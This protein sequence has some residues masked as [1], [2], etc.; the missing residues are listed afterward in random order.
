[1]VVA[2]CHSEAVGRA[3]VAAKKNHVVCIRA[4]DELDDTTATTFASNFY[5][6]LLC[7]TNAT[8][9]GAFQFADASLR[10]PDER[11]SNRFLLLP[12][13]GAHDAEI[14]SGLADSDTEGGVDGTLLSAAGADNFVGRGSEMAELLA[15]IAS[16][17]RVISVCGLSG[18]GKTALVTAT[19]AYMLA[20]PR[21]KFPRSVV[22]KLRDC[23]SVEDASF[24]VRTAVI[25]GCDEGPLFPATRDLKA[26]LHGLTG[27]LL[28]VLE[29]ADVLL[30]DPAREAGFNSLLGII[31][32]NT[33]GSK[34]VLTLVTSRRVA[35]RDFPEKVVTLSAMVP[36]EA[37]RLFVQ[38]APQPLLAKDAQAALRVAVGGSALGA[39][40]HQE[41]RSADV[42]KQDMFLEKLRAATG[43]VLE[44]QVFASTIVHL[45]LLD[46]LAGYP[47]AIV[48][49]AV[50]TSRFSL[51]DVTMRV[52]REGAPGIDGVVVAAVAQQLEWLAGAK[53]WAYWLLVL[54]GM[55]PGG[56]SVEDLAMLWG[57]H[58]VNYCPNCGAQGSGDPPPAVDI[59]ACAA[60]MCCGAVAGMCPA[61]DWSLA[62]CVRVALTDLCTASLAQQSTRRVQVDNGAVVSVLPV[63]GA[64]AIERASQS[65][66]AWLR[67]VCISS[68]AAACRQMYDRL[69]D[70][71]AAFEVIQKTLAREEPNVWQCLKWQSDES[72]R[73][74]PPVSHDSPA[75][76][77]SWEHVRSG[78][79]RTSSRTP[80]DEEKEEG[81]LESPDSAPG[82]GGGGSSDALYALV[83]LRCIT[84]KFPQIL[85]NCGRHDDAQQVR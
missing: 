55:C 84:S 27:A 76:A 70:R 32:N 21:A 58:C 81:A 64:A 35:M 25:S 1:M 26:C 59:G 54:L 60:D 57:E 31:L 43:A 71:A 44:K 8:V 45:P 52:I 18:I 72:A 10:L 47:V 56:K 17:S 16:D 23:M 19:V 30:K 67:C 14:F 36:I 85:D 68:S 42:G 38:R 33:P 29:N 20:R 78:T 24:R 37:A 65:E 53:P 51:Q 15:A 80:A 13:G 9:M 2:S 49:A 28:L 73:I 79:P 46:F 6:S 4:S 3:L 63:I 5:K 69:G 75:G 34:I 12:T 74:V 62:P 48:A 22:V 66:R 77:S 40:W 39:S 11:Q 83:G 82:G 61:C 50:S 7:G 41:M